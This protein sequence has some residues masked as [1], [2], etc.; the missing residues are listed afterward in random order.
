M[1]SL[2]EEA[3]VTEREVLDEFVVVPTQAYASSRIL[4]EAFDE[5]A[6]CACNL[7]C[8]LFPHFC[9]TL[10]HLAQRAARR[11][12]VTRR[13]IARI[14]PPSSERPNCAIRNASH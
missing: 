14:F 1:T 6:L 5:A 13:A 11:R 8:E 9:R 10:S 7:L 3:P 4:P 12:H 2:D